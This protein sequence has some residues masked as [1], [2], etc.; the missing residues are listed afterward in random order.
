[1]NIESGIGDQ[2]FFVQAFVPALEDLAARGRRLTVELRNWGL[3]PDTIE[4]FRRTGLDIVVSTK[5]FAEH[6]AMP[7]QPPAMRG[8]YSYDS[9]LRRDKPFPFQWHVWNLGSHRLFA[10]G[11]PD[12]V[13]RFA[14]SCHLGDG[15]GFEVTPPGSQKGF[16]QWGQVTPGDWQARQRPAPAPRLSS[17]TGSSTWPLGG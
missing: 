10:W 3:H 9:F 16:S 17:A 11:D 2:R 1:M 6:Q 5:Y 7:Y 14:R 12:Y 8:S 15:V 4:A 13:R